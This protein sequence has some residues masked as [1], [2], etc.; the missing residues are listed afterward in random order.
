L[1]EIEP[2]FCS[3]PSGLPPVESTGKVNPAEASSEGRTVGV[4]PIPRIASLSEKSAVAWPVFTLNAS[5]DP[6]EVPVL[7]NESQIFRL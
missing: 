5:V 3:A 2:A 1:H 6:L 4:D 7:Q